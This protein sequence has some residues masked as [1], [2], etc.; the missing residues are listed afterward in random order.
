MI[1]S[2]QP[3]LNTSQPN[4]CKTTFGPIHESLRGC[5]DHF[6]PLWACSDCVQASSLSSNTKQIIPKQLYRSICNISS[7]FENYL[8]NS[9]NVSNEFLEGKLGGIDVIHYGCG[10]GCN[11]GKE[12]DLLFNG[13]SGP[14]HVYLADYQTFHDSKSNIDLPKDFLNKVNENIIY[15]LITF[16]IHFFHL[17]LDSL[18]AHD[19]YIYTLMEQLFK[20]GKLGEV[21]Q[22]HGL[23]LFFASQEI[24]R[25]RFFKN[26][27]NFTVTYSRIHLET[28]IYFDDTLERFLYE[29]RKNQEEL[30]LKC[31][32]SKEMIR[33]KFSNYPSYQYTNNYT[34]QL[35]MVSSWGKRTFD[36][37]GIK[38]IALISNK[39]ERG[40]YLINDLPACLSCYN[41]SVGKIIGR[42]YKD[43][44][45]S[46]IDIGSG[47]LC[48]FTIFDNEENLVGVVTAAHVIRKCQ[49]F[50]NKWRSDPKSEILII[51]PPTTEGD[52]LGWNMKEKPPFT[53]NIS[54]VLQRTEEGIQTYRGIFDH[55]NV[56]GA[57]IEIDQSTLQGMKSREVFQ[58]NSKIFKDE[59]VIIIQ[60]PEGKYGWDSGKILSIN[61][62][63]GRFC[64]TVSTLPGSSG[65]SIITEFGRVVGIHVDRGTV[66]GKSG[67][68]DLVDEN[69][70]LSIIRFA[71]ELKTDYDHQRNKDSN[72][73]FDLK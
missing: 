17:S 56:D 16:R 57:F 42:S 60:F 3:S 10:A 61:E 70:G 7:I 44:L 4:P 6:V 33:K 13:H 1:V 43:P 46:G 14:R 67:Q 28:V 62:E 23:I 20:D 63:E 34:Y 71:R 41:S 19:K 35:R 40:F 54:K 2:T 22:H 38:P 30:L 59:N 73:F 66:V 55:R 15:P 21:G 32:I 26:I 36:Y 52:P 24:M 47:F 45:N 39:F 48:S 29:V 50:I 58:L 68:Y 11:E 25:T 27:A 8:A 64:H 12:F 49:E 72:F 31:G 9:H 69:V 65:S 5:K 37:V 18:R 53:I 51:F